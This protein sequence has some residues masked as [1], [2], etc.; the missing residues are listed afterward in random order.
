MAIRFVST[1]CKA[2]VKQQDAM[3]GPGG[4]EPAVV[5]WGFESGIIV[6]ES[7]VHVLKGRRRAGGWA[8]REAEAVGLVD[9]V[10]GVLA[11][12]D[13]FDCVEGGVARPARMIEMRMSIEGEIESRG[14]E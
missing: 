4:K 7:F 3:V 1:H 10:V 9:V 12:D 13:G 6:L 5:G 8:D 11:E 2:R 14:K